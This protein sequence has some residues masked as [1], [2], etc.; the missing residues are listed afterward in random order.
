MKGRLEGSSVVLGP[1]GMALHE[2]GGFGRVERGGLRLAAE[3]ALYLVHRQ[4]LEVEGYPF[5]RL[6][7]AFADRPGLFRS[8]LVYRDIRERGYAVQPGLGHYRLFRRGEKPGTG[9]SRLLVRVLSERDLVDFEVIRTEV[10]TSDNMRKDHV[11]AVVDDEGELTY[12]GVKMT[13]LAT[14]STPSAY[15]SFTGHL[16]G[17]TVILKDAIPGEVR[18]SWFGTPLDEKRVILSPV[19]TLYLMQ[20]GCLSFSGADASLTPGQYLA[21]AL[22]SDPELAEKASVYADMRDQGYIPRTGYKFGHHFR[23]YARDRTHSDLLV[24]AV[25]PGQTLSVSVISRSV[26]LAHSVK[27][28]MLF[29]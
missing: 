12:Y 14:I 18:E 23:V 6:L 5:D 11:L 22:P 24:H 29:A 1:D 27:K 21:S 2:Q 13:A 7:S 19:E 28:K 4:K 17:T 20:R 3:E 26:R 25:P 9:R 10:E 16:F 8:Y 15:P